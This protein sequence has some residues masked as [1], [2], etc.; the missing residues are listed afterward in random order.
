M[1][2]RGA[3]VLI[4]GA[5]SGI[6]A[7]TAR[8]VHNRGGRAL[9][10]ARRKEPLAALAAELGAVAYPCDA[11]DPAAVADLAERVRADGN[12][13]DVIVNNAGAGRF[14][15]L[16]ETSASDLAEMTAVPYFAAFRITRAFIE[17][18]L[19]RRSGWIVNVNSPASRAVWPG[20][21]AYS[22]ARWALRGFD[23]ALG[24]ELRGTGIGVTEVIPG[25]V[26]SD[27]FV[28]NPGSEERVP[29]ISRLIRTLSCEEV[30]AA[31]CSGVERERRRVLIP[32]M[33]RLIDA[34]ARFLPGPTEWLLWRTG[35]KRKRRT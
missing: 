34:Q 18:M 26:R 30:A 28:H 32:R 14:L 33:L 11:S 21:I 6:G 17:N 13:P 7:A 10:V 27:Y 29:K 1:N 35:A 16:E 12:E 19:E 31:L 24:V 25:K 23:T 3:T 2:L 9:L 15:F 20:A 4:T 8:E 22:G 5:S